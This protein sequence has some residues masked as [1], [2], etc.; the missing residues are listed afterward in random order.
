MSDLCSSGFIHRIALQTFHI[1]HIERDLKDEESVPPQRWSGVTPQALLVK[2]PKSSG[3]P[4][5]RCKMADCPR[6]QGEVSDF[7]AVFLYWHRVVIAVPPATQ[8]AQLFAPKPKKA[9]LYVYAMRITHIS[10]FAP[11][12]WK[13]SC[14]QF[15][16]DSFS[17]S[18]SM[19]GNELLFFLLLSF[20]SQVARIGSRSRREAG[21]NLE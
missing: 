8:S 18:Y 4:F 3:E 7:H 15:L 9:M 11:K 17:Y 6:S 13:Q 21:W 14:K 5:D 2:I 20:L 1:T 16:P 19:T 10:S 12:L